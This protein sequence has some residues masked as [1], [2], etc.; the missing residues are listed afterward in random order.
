VEK[1]MSEEKLRIEARV[2]EYVV[3]AMQED[4]EDGY[5][6]YDATRLEILAPIE[7]RGRQVVIFHD[8]PAPPGSL[9]RKIGTRFRAQIAR[10]SLTGDDTLFAGAFSNLQE[11]PE[12]AQ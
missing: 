8:A 2:Q 10:N 3:N 12:G 5:A 4:F 7:F 6:S 9:W 1:T 11:V